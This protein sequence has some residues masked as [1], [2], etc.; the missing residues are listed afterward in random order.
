MFSFY[1][2]NPRPLSYSPRI[3]SVYPHLSYPHSRPLVTSPEVR[4]RRALGEYL[5]AEGE[6]NALLGAR[7]VKLRAHAEALR[8][9]QAR[10]RLAQ[11]ARARKERL[12]EQGLA[13]AL[14]RAAV[15]EDDDLSLHHVVPVTVM[16]RTSKRPLSDMRAPRCTYPRLSCAVFDGV[17]DEKVCGV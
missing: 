9:E 11:V 10:L 17:G 14:A 5:T 12:V 13:R 15:S 3:Y 7:E 16:Y 2:S 4:Y 8:R 1:P 6:Y